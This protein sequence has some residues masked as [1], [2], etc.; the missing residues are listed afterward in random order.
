MNTRARSNLQPM[1]APG[2]LE[3]EKM[4]VQSNKRMHTEKPMINRRK[5]TREKKMALLQD[6]DKLKKKLR[7]E[8]NVHRALE[9]AFTRPLGALPR[10]PP[11]L[12][13][14]TLEL[15][16]EVAVLEEEVVRLEEQVVH[17]R[18]GLYK[19]A[20]YISSSK[21]NMDNLAEQCDSC[22][23]PKLKQ[24]KL[25]PRVEAHSDDGVLK[26]DQSYLSSKQNQKSSNVNSQTVRTPVKRLPIE[27]RPI[28][29]RLDPQKIVGTEE[30]NSVTQ[31]RKASG[32]DSPN[33]ISENIV[34]CLLNVFSRMSS[35]R[36]RSSAETLSSLP[37]I[38]FCDSSVTTQFKDPYAISLKFGK[39]DIGPYKHLFAVEAPSIN[40]NRSTVSV[41]LVRRLKLLLEKLESVKLKGLT[42]QQKLAFWIN[43]Y[44]SCMMNAFLENGIPESPEMVVALM[45]KATINVG[46]HL[47]NAITIEH[48]ILRL[49]YHSK[50]TFEKGIKN[51]EMTARSIFG[52]EFS[53]PL[54]TFALSCGSWS[55]PAVRVYTASKIETELEVAKR[56][57]LQAAIGISSAKKT[58]AIPK[59]L[60]WYLLDFAKDLESLLDWIC[61]QLPSE[62]GKE[63]LSCLERGNNE[64]LSQ[65]LEIIPYEFSFRYL[66]CM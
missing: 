1:K 38:T 17:F 22:K 13:S 44:N 16:A 26:E 51:D 35:K 52:L 65:V 2:K 55:S 40:P 31:D 57:Y 33:K 25:S 24:T 64:P 6:V 14:S 21:R 36:T 19:E 30:R 49:P 9:R 62:L 56:E 23:S 32:D 46:G 29:K 34:K 43:I 66:L 45:Q 41:F 20:V 11:Y 60:D 54:V 47:L 5:A 4:G 27:N 61:L 7:H 10:L 42:H 15:L 28:E 18:Q 59:L 3:K 53:E 39:R 50:F 63:A 48:F 37:A 12:P 8:E 58:V